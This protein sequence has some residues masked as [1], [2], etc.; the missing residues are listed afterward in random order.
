MISIDE[1]IINLKILNHIFFDRC[2]L[3]KT[4]NRITTTPPKAIMA[5]TKTNITYPN[6]IIIKLRTMIMVKLT[7][8]SH[9]I[10]IRIRNPNSVPIIN[11]PIVIFIA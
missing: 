3:S 6:K 8:P 7:P 4:H 10:I 11:K 2:I 1:I 5:K 9:N